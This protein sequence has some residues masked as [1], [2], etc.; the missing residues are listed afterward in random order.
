MSGAAIPAL[1]TR[2]W[3]NDDHP[4]DYFESGDVHPN[5][6]ITS[7]LGYAREGFRM[8]VL[9]GS[10]R[11]D[12][13]WERAILAGVSTQSTA[14][15]ICGYEGGDLDGTWEGIFTVRAGSCTNWR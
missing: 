11:W 9:T 5:E 13:D 1:L 2:Q 4:E 10:E 7:G 15:T 3:I 8:K 12:V 14:G 6:P